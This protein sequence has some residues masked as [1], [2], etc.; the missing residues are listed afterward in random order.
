[1]SGSP[2]PDGDHD[3][4]VVDASDCADGG[5]RLDLTIIAGEHKGL[6]LTITS[7]SSMGDAITLLGLPATISVTAGRPSVRL[8]P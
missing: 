7:S 3:A 8:E 6:V 5:T 2:L 1:M 4:I